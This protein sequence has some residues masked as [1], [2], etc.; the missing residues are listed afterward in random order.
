[1]SPRTVLT[2]AALALMVS[3]LALV[4][5]SLAA[6]RAKA[7]SIY[8]GAQIGSQF[9]GNAAP[10]NMKAVSKFQHVTGK[11]LSTVGWTAPFSV[12]TGSSCAPYVFPDTAME[13]VRDY[14]AVPFLAWGSEGS[15]G[16]TQPDFQL[17]DVINGKYD[18]YIST[19]ASKA[20]QW[21]HPFLLRFNWEMN[22]N[23]FP[24]SERANGNKPGEYVAAWRHVHDIFTSMG[25]TNASW[26]WCPN[27]NINNNSA[28][29]RN[30]GSLYPGNAYVDWTCIDG[31]NWGKRSGSPG[32]LSFSRIYRRTYRQVVK[33]APSKPMILGEI[34]S[35]DYGGSKA[36]WIRNMLHVIPRHYR[37]IHGLVW[38]D[39]ND[40]GAHWPIETSRSAK[41]AFRHGI[42]S[43]VYARNNFANLNASPI[44]VP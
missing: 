17:S 35:S 16:A 7:S 12:C 20:R 8:W 14:G 36:A 1:M 9:T 18:S 39:V 24:W 33:I 2:A 22:G 21:G 43:R 23:W 15:G 27:V 13:D 34:A 29:Q 3:C 11:G 42:H 28:L 6:K 41:K 31:F 10:Y 44:P 37:K 4:S 40:R 32:W 25:A 26:V 38:F 5:A 19:F 30:L